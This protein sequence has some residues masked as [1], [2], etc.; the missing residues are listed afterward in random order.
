MA[1]QIKQTLQKVVV[2][3]LGVLDTLQALDVKVTAVAKG[4]LPSYLSQ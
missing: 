4:I 1:M 3:D 2:F